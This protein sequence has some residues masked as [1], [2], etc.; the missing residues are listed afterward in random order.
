MAE[1]RQVAAP[2]AD[3][4]SDPYRT[5]GQVMGIATDGLTEHTWNGERCNDIYLILA[6][7]TDR[8]ELGPVSERDKIQTTI[9]Q[10]TKEWL[11]AADETPRLEELLQHWRYE[12]CGY[13][14]P[15]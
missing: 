2:I 1:M 6:G 11:D 10:F 9:R 15:A 13:E 12:E 8:F 14:R 4:S 3:G 5:V 7:L